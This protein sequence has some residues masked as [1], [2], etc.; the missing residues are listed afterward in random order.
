MCLLFIMKNRRRRENFYKLYYNN[1]VL[2]R[3]VP[4]YFVGISNVYQAHKYI[5]HQSLLFIKFI[6]FLGI[7]VTIICFT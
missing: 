6:Y 7:R 5:S 4:T 1:I 2:D 3:K